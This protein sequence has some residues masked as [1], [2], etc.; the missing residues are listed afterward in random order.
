M[1]KTEQHNDMSKIEMA[2]RS[3]RQQT[4]SES[5]VLKHESNLCNL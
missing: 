5:Q 4:G 3:F 2:N 1:K